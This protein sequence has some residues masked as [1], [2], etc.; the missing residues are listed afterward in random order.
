MNF[1]NRKGIYL[2]GGWFTP[3]QME[4]LEWVRDELKRLGFKLF[5][6]KDDALC[7]PD[8]NSDLKT[9]IFEGNKSEIKKSQMVFAITN[10]KDMG[11]LMEVGMGV[12]MM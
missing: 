7:P 9:R 11:T 10:E 1:I 8:A 4:R 12:C 3:S 2:A 6:P 5:S